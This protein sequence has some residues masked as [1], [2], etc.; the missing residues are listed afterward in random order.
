METVKLKLKRTCDARRS[1]MVGDRNLLGVTTLEA[2]EPVLTL[3]L[4]PRIA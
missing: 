3:P 1:R 4:M 2:L